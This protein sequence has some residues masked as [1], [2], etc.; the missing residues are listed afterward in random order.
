MIR[1]TRAVQR[2]SES[3]GNRGYGYWNKLFA[4]GRRLAFALTPALSRRERGPEGGHGGPLPTWRERGQEGA[5]R[6]GAVGGFTL[7]ETMLAVLIMAL[8]ASAAALSF[9]APMRAARAR[10]AFDQLISADRSARQASRDGGRVVRLSFDPSDGAVSRFLGGKMQFRTRLPS[11][12][13]MD[14]VLIGRRAIRSSIAEVEFSASG[15][16]ST[17]AVHVIG[18]GVDR[19]ILFAGLTGQA[20]VVA[21]EQAVRLAV[22][23]V[24]PSRHNPD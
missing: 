3:I 5:R 2:E 22:E 20:S 23:N 6:T 19:W 21:D 7:I 9:A 4:N 8:L 10:E 1:S 18:P 13:Q 16:S 11:S 14:G 12:F 15:F 17:Y 24:A